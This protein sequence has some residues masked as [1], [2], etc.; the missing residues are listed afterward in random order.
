MHEL[1]VQLVDGTPNLDGR[2]NSAERV[3]FVND[4]D[5]EHRH[6]RVADELLDSRSVTAEDLRDRLEVAK[7]QVT[8]LLWIEGRA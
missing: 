5:P 8:H 2:T 7:H 1:R 3:V 4:R 6:D